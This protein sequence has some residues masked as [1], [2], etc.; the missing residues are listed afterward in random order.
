MFF[1]SRRPACPFLLGA[2]AI[3]LSLAPAHA[4][5]PVPASVG[6]ANK[7]ELVNLVHEFQGNTIWSSKLMLSPA[8][9]NGVSYL[10]K[11]AGNYIKA[12]GGGDLDR[13]EE[14]NSSDRQSSQGEVDRL[15]AQSKTKFSFTMEATQPK[16]SP[17]QGSLMLN[18]LAVVAGFLDRGDWTPRGGRANIKLVFSCTAKDV[19]VTTSKDAT[20]FTI[21][22]PLKEPSDWG[23]KIERGLKRG[24]K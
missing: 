24:G 4:Q 12:Q 20:N 15:I 1:H 23:G 7:A 16:L 8:G 13:V 21:I 3:L 10:S 14:S 5:A 18:Y 2:T 22:A 6:A 19:A 11:D 9:V 17:A